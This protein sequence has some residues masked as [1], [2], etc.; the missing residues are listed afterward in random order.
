[1]ISSLT[2]TYKHTIYIE[3]N[4]WKIPLLGVFIIIWREDGE[5]AGRITIE[6]TPIDHES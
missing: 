3:R 6:A 2:W 1:M 5:I 4:I